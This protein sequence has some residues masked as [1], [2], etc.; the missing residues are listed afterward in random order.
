M[1]KQDTAFKNY[2]KRKKKEVFV[3][4]HQFGCP[5]IDHPVPINEC[6]CDCYEYSIFQA[7]Y[8]AGKDTDTLADFQDTLDM[9]DESDH[10]YSLVIDQHIKD[11]D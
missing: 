2:M 3:Y 10:H 8:K 11:N 4:N 6:I 9:E 5:M 7:G 1:P